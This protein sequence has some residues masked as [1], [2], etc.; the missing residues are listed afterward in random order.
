MTGGAVH[1]RDAV[2]ARFVGKLYVSQELKVEHKHP[3]IIDMKILQGHI[4]Q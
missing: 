2:D 3:G 1:H 4:L